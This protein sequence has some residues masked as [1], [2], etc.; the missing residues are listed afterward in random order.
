MTVSAEMVRQ[1][2]NKTG[3]GMMDCKKALTEAEGDINKAIEILRK[4]GL[5]QA[6]KKMGRE[7]SEGIIS[8]YIH[9]DKIG[10]MI[11]VNCE[12]DFVAR[13]DDFRQF[14]KDI[15]MHIAAANPLYLDKESVPEEIIKKEKEIFKGQVK[16]KPAHVIDKIVEGKME[17]FYTENCLLEQIFVK[18]PAQKKKIKDLLK[19]MIAKFGENINIKRFVRFQ[20]GEEEQK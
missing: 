3:A 7:T 16:N 2:R 15:A 20:L 18:D 13:T 19:E 12:T 8:S 1:L 17:K 6:E 4:K 9:M 5:A 14:V 11:E 10:V